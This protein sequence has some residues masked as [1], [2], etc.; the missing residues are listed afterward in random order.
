MRRLRIW[1]AMDN[2]AEAYRR[3]E[4][5]GAKGGR[6]IDQFIFPSIANRRQEKV[7]MMRLKIR[8]SHKLVGHYV[9]TGCGEVMRRDGIERSFLCMRQ[10]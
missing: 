7:T 8:D 9:S 4:G 5:E 1:A 10:R 2:G 6:F 3:T